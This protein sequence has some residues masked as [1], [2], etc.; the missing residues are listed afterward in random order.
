MSGTVFG[1]RQTEDFERDVIHAIHC[2]HFIDTTPLPLC[3]V[4][5]VPVS[6]GFPHGRTSCATLE[7]ARV[8]LMC[9]RVLYVF[10][11]L[12]A[13]IVGPKCVI[14]TELDITWKGRIAE[15]AYQR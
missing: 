10:G 6:G 2:N 4:W 5:P 15:G 9:D 14:T 8:V 11:R 13:C 3:D 1:A 7:L 12:S